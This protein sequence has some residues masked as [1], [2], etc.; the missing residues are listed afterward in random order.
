MEKNDFLG[1]I[2]ILHTCFSAKDE[3][4]IKPNI[5]N[6]HIIAKRANIYL[7]AN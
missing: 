3:S 2:R 1:Q 7:R 5:M 6:V 4:H